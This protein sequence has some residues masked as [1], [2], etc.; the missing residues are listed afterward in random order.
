MRIVECAD[1]HLRE[2]LPHPAP[3]A[4]KYTRGTLLFVGGAADYPGAASLAIGAAERMGAGYVEAHCALEA[5]PLVRVTRLSAVVRS[6]DA[7]VWDERPCDASHLWACAV[8]SGMDG[9]DAAQASLV[10]GAMQDCCAPLI[11][12]GGGLTALASAAGLRAADVRAVASTPLVLTPHGGEA[13]R[14]AAAAG[15]VVPAGDAA[16]ERLASFAADLACAWHAT[17]LLKGSVSYIVSHADP[18]RAFAMRQGTAALAKAGTGDV[19]A[20]MVGA[21]LAQGLSAT[22]AC[23]LASTLHA[24]AARIAQEQ[25]SDISV[26]AEDVLAAIPQAILNL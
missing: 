3:D 18:Q 10:M 23:V 17:V 12:D 5:M 11:V 26:I 15:V 14:L 24:K 4:N 6:W 20:G 13:A 7:L 9:T 2:L 1:A 8:G 25:Q 22:D 19:L 21:L 16:P